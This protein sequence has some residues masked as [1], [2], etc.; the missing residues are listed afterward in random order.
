LIGACDVGGYISL[1]FEGYHDNLRQTLLAIGMRARTVP[2]PRNLWMNIPISGNGALTFQPTVSR[3]DE[4]VEF[5]AVMDCVV[6]MSACPMDLN[7]I[8]GKKPVDVHFD[9]RESA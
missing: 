8:N 3:P 7:S 1:G 4:F 9:V 5:S 6:V 2:Q